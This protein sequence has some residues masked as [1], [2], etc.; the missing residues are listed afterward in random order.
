MFDFELTSIDF[1]CNGLPFTFLQ[2]AFSGLR[3]G[4]TYG[5]DFLLTVGCVS[6][7]LATSLSSTH[8]WPTES[9]QPRLAIFPLIFIYILGI[10]YLAPVSN[11]YV[12][13]GQ[14]DA[15]P[16]KEVHILTFRTYKCVTLHAWQRDF[17]DVTKVKDLELRR[18]F[19]VIWEAQCDHS[20][21]SEG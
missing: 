1:W 17:A 18:V 13:S 2:S 16:F 11:L 15:P 6:A 19:W 5:V 14:D 3:P 7:L 21:P 9:G 12:C 8:L 20:G 10:V 4:G